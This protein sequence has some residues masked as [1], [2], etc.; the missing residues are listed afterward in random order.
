MAQKTDKRNVLLT[1]KFRVAFPQVAELKSFAPDQKGRYSCVALFTLAEFTEK[2]KAKWSALVAACHKVALDEFKK[3]W[4]ELDRSV[5][6]LPFHK[7]EEKEQYSGFGPGVIYFTMSAYTRR[8]TILGPDNVT[9]VDP[10]DFYPGCYAR[11]S[12]NP[13]ASTKWKSI[14]IGMNHLQKLGEGDRLDGA[15]SAEEDFGADANEYDTSADSGV[16]DDLT[17]DIG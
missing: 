9:P 8:P 4:K 3:P 11:A 7:G 13:F 6:K 17:D 14:S 15:T 5:Y 2:D 16:A 10:A 12:V 1:P